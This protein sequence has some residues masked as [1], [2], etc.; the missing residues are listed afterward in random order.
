MQLL[1]W[2]MKWCSLC[3]PEPPELDNGH[4]WAYSQHVPTCGQKE[5]IWNGVLVSEIANVYVRKCKLSRSNFYIKKWRI[6][7][8]MSCSYCNTHRKNVLILFS[9]STVW[10][11]PQICRS[12]CAGGVQH[13]GSVKTE[14]RRAFI[15]TVWVVSTLTPRGLVTVTE[16]N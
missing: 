10:N 14:V 13:T 11:K 15:R 2:G 3:E 8:A 1:H 12:V 16:Q 4:V 7:I 5:S 9:P 6:H